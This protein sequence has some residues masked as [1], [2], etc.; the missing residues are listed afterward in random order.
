MYKEVLSA[1]SDV[2]IYPVTSLLLFVL[3][4]GIAFVRAM[5]LDRRHLDEAARLPLDAPDCSGR[6]QPAPP[7]GIG[8]KDRP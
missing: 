4:F 7:A 5:R 1:I 8:G 3:A 2:N 6:L